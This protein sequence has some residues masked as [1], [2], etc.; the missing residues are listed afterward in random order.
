GRSGLRRHG[1]GQG[2]ALGGGLV[3]ARVDRVVTSGTFALDG[4]T[5]DV[6][7]NVWLIGDDEEVLVV[8]AAHDADAIAAAVGDRHVR[9]ILCTHGHNDHVTVAP[10]LSERLDAPVLLHPGD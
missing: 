1:R 2:A 8:D 7:N 6:D 3:S 10:Q 5:W 9:A 4:G